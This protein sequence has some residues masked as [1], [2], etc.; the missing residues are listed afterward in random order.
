MRFTLPGTHKVN[1]HLYAGPADVGFNRGLKQMKR[2]QTFIFQNIIKSQKYDKLH[3]VRT[4]F[5]ADMAMYIPF[6]EHT[7]NCTTLHLMGFTVFE[8]ANLFSMY[9]TSYFYYNPPP[10]LVAGALYSTNVQIYCNIPMNLH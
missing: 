10:I 1:W 3:I 5:V 9:G 8:D 7:L 2:V 4:F 6:R